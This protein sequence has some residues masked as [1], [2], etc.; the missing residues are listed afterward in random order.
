MITQLKKGSLELCVLAL[1]DHQDSYGFEI[2]ETIS[3]YV[4]V[5]EGS[6]YPLLRRL[7]QEGYTE[8]YF[9]QSTEGPA[10][11]YYFLT[12]EGKEYYREMYHQWMVFNQE[13]QK[14]FMTYH[15]ENVTNESTNRK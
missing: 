1:I 13:V 6:I 12:N 14:F 9:H 4:E 11:K 15:K 10:R 2:V 7:T 3:K 5:S 8:S